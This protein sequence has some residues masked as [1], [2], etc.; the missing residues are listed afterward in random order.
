MAQNDLIDLSTLQNC[1]NPETNSNI[2]HIID[3]NNRDKVTD[4]QFGLAIVNAQSITSGN[5]YLLNHLLD[6]TQEGASTRSGL[7][8]KFILYRPEKNSKTFKLTDYLKEKN[9]NKSHV[10]IYYCDDQQNIYRLSTDY[11]F[12]ELVTQTLLSLINKISYLENDIQHLRDE[13]SYSYAF[14]YI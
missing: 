1:F 11:R 3:T 14:S 5:Q 6:E 2:Q 12:N 4:N 10:G 9:D 7:E 13:I 8:N